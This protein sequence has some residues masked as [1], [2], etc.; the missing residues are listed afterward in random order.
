MNLW[1]RAEILTTLDSKQQT[2]KVY[3]IDYGT[4]ADVGVRDI[5]YLKKDYSVLPAQAYRGC[6]DNIKPVRHK[7]SRDASYSML[8]MVYDVLV[9]AKVTDINYETRVVYMILVDTNGEEDLNINNALVQK[10][11]AT[12]HNVK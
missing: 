3:F 11:F 8:A 1:H 10:G 4:T 5:K 2:C 6:L 12:V 7:W 9:Y